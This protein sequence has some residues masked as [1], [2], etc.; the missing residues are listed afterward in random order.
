MSAITP[1]SFLRRP[2]AGILAFAFLFLFQAPEATAKKKHTGPKGVINGRVLTQAE[3]IIPGVSVTVQGSNFEEQ[4]TTDEQ[5]TFSVE[6]PNAS[7]TYKVH[8]E[9]DG[10]APFE[11]S[12]ELSVDETQNLD[13]RLLDA[14]TGRK[15]DAIRIYNQGAQAFSDG[16][17]ARAK[18]IFLEATALNPELAEPLLGLTDIYLGENDYAKAAEV[19]E[20]YLA[21]KP[22]DENVRQMA[23]QAYLA[24]GNEEKVNEYRERMAGTDMASGLAVQVFNEGALA[25]QSGDLAKAAEK[26][27]AAL[28]LN[29]KLKEAWSALSVVYYNQQNFKGALEAAEKTLELD[30]ADQQGLRMRYIALDA[31]NDQGRLA[32]ALDAYAAVNPKGA[33]QILYQR[34]DF[35]FRDGLND[36]AQKALLRVLELDPEMARAHYTLGLTYAST[37]TAKAKEHLLKFIE[38]APDDPEVT[39]A[40]EM[41]DYF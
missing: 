36:A 29:P 27:L 37:N 1:S 38:M 18:E 32:E 5:G 7:G 31:L 28:E 30:P 40:Q 19:A 15:Q 8:F 25:S 14:V 3:E 34:A 2:L 20:K 22:E 16:D 23:Y 26:F 17:K 21:L 41:V 6:I 13:F 24:L 9:K 12:L 10:Y 39:T 33:A 35:D 11:V 4:L